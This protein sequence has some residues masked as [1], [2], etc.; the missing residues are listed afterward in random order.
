MLHWFFY[1]YLIGCI[2][3]GTTGMIGRRLTESGNWSRFKQELYLRQPNKN[4]RIPFFDKNLASDKNAALRFFADKRYINTKRVN[5]ALAQ[6]DLAKNSN[7]GSYLIDPQNLFPDSLESSEPLNCRCGIPPCK[8]PLQ[9][10]PFVEPNLTHNTAIFR[11]H[12][13][14]MNGKHFF[15]G[16]RL[17]YS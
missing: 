4:A 16:E 12:A 15:G 17:A 14:L 9:R 6:M 13:Q 1:Y 5:A 7:L 3:F 10:V 11:R 8:I 2:L